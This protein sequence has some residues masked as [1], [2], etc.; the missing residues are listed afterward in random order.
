M[1]Y[2]GIEAGEGGGEGRMDEEKKGVAA[3]AD[4]VRGVVEVGS[5]RGGEGRRR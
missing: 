5:G 3:V 4:E 1:S 2:N